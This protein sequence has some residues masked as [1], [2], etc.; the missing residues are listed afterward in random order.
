[1]VILAGGAFPLPDYDLFSFLVLPLLEQQAALLG[2]LGGEGEIGFQ[3]KTP[4][5][6]KIVS[7]EQ[8]RP[9]QPGAFREEVRAAR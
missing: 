9:L 2:H 4:L 1:L 3:Y 6:G 7:P 5:G 8:I